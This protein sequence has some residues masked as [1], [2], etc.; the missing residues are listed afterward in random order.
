MSRLTWGDAG[1]RE[2]QAGL[3]RGVVYIDGAAHAWS[4]LV[5]VKTEVKKKVESVFYDGVKVDDIVVH[6]G[7]EGEIS[8]L[9]YPDAFEACMGWS[10]TDQVGVFASEQFPERFHLTWRSQIGNDQEALGSDYRIHL[11]YNATAIA[12][13]IE[14]ET[15]T[16]ETEPLEFEWDITAVAEPVSGLRPACH[17]ILDT[18]KMDPELVGDLET[19]L[20]GDETTDPSMPPMRSIL[21]FIEKWDRIIVKDLGNGIFTVTAGDELTINPDG[22]W[23]LTDANA[24]NITADSYDL[25]STDKNDE[26]V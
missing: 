18:R 12:K 6:E 9:T 1:T 13:D 10:E 5:S 23:I 14:Y 16:D 22:S 26:D 4:G 3:D 19:I 21:T 8:A 20:Y 11:L 7:F 2:Y 25:S 17:Y 15:I 24:T